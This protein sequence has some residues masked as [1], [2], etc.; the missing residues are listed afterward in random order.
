M[1]SSDSVGFFENRELL[2]QIKEEHQQIV[3]RKRTRALRLSNSLQRYFQ[4]NKKIIPFRLTNKEEEG[5]IH[6]SQLFT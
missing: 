2:A 1:F 3:A 6:E 4:K 5:K